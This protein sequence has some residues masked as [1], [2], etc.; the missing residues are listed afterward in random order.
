MISSV[1]PALLTDAPHS[2]NHYCGKLFPATV[3]EIG[4][5]VAKKLGSRNYKIQT[6]P[7]L[8]QEYEENRYFR[9][10]VVTSAVAVDGKARRFAFLIPM[11]ASLPCSTGLGHS[12]S[13][14]C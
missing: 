13:K 5:V 1:I 2:V 3:L 6:E 12:R 4:N 10:S 14:S 11:Q 9:Q 7:L 8:V